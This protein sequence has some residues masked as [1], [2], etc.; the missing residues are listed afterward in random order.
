ML[1]GNK[2]EKTLR[3]MNVFARHGKCG[4]LAFFKMAVKLLIFLS[5]NANT[6]V[7]VVLLSGFITESAPLPD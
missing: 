7:F 4:T 3:R 5:D 6:S 2:M 1:K